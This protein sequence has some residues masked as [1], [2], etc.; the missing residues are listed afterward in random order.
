MKKKSIVFELAGGLGNQIFQYLAAKYIEINLKEANI[1]FRESLYLKK[2]YRQLEIIKIIS[3]R[4]N[5]YETS[6]K[7]LTIAPNKIL[8]KLKLL[9]SKRTLDL[10][11]NIGLLK[12]LSEKNIENSY[13]TNEP[14]SQLLKILKKTNSNEIKIEGY[15]QNPEIYSKS[16]SSFYKYFKSTKY[17]LSND[18]ISNKYIGIHVRRGDYTSNKNIYNYYF[19]RFSPI[20]YIISSLKILPAELKSL[21]IYIVSDDPK[22]VSLW[23]DQIK[24]KHN[25][26]NISNNSNPLIDWSIL[27]YSRLNI[28]ANSTFSYT[29]SMLNKENLNE[30]IRAIVPQ[31]IST[32]E[33]SYIKGWLSFPGF[34]EI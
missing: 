5:F 26:V 12:V 22:W 30:K 1:F 8:L 24:T 4:I 25:K 32:D 2:K 13:S 3:E 34:I 27:R 18:L 11:N 9:N 10:I 28:C 19:K 20:P 23:A 33:S 17:L 21:P 6:N 31:W 14:L 15:W 7:F 16:I 29:A